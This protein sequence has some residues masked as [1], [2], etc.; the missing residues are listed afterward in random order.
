[1]TNTEQKIQGNLNGETPASVA[2]MQQTLAMVM[3]EQSAILTGVEALLAMQGE[4]LQAVLGK[5]T[6]DSLV[7][8]AASR[9]QQKM[10]V[11]NGGIL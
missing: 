1:M 7:G 10:A 3:E 8:Q 11:V 2:N 6:S 4:L 9:Y 5:Q